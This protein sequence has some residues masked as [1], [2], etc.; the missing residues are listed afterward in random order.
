[1]MPRRKI[2]YAIPSTWK[3]IWNDK[4]KSDSISTKNHQQKLRLVC[5]D[6][7]EEFWFETHLK[8]WHDVDKTF[9]PNQHIPLFPLHVNIVYSYVH[10]YNYT[11]YKNRK[12]AKITFYFA[13]INN[14]KVVL[15]NIK[16]ST[17]LILIHIYIVCYIHTGSYQIKV[18]YIHTWLIHICNKYAQE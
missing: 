12:R 9:S 10:V 14:L 3:Q 15:F 2:L 18:I 13:K 7:Y 1:M 16:C 6:L 5:P 8:S 4:N 11:M 17:H